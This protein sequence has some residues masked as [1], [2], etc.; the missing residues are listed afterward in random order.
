[1]LY[2]TNKG[3]TKKSKTKLQDQVRGVAKNSGLEGEPGSNRDIF[4]IVIRK[5]IYIY[6]YTEMEVMSLIPPWHYKKTAR[7]EMYW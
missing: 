3:R 4:C 6:M 5:C 2:N 7:M 1:M